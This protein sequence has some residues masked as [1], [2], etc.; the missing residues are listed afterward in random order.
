MTCADA[1]ATRSPIS[2]VADSQYKAIDMPDVMHG[3][4]VGPVTI[5]TSIEKDGKK[6]KCKINCP[7][8]D[9]FLHALIMTE[10]FTHC[11]FVVLLKTKD[12]ATDAVMK[13]IRN[14]QNKTGRK[15]LRFQ[16]DGAGELSKTQRLI[17]HFDVNM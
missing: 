12:E 5:R 7:T 3:D 10:E 17:Q 8:F 1:K 11:V 4:L 16:T 6:I 15:V 14:V 13:I 2:K 9:G